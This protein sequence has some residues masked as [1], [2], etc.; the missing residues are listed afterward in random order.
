MAFT[1][2]AGD[3]SASTFH[4]AVKAVLPIAIAA[5][6]LMLGGSLMWL[7]VPLR[8]DAMGASDRQIGLL[9]TG[10]FIGFLGG[11]LFAS[12]LIRRLRHLKAFFF[13]A[14]IAALAAVGFTLANS[15]PLFFLLRVAYGFANAGYFIAMESW[16]NELAKNEVRSR[17]MTF[18]M[19]CYYLAGGAG[20]LLIN[21]WPP[22]DDTGLWVAAIV[23][24]AAVIP[25]LQLRQPERQARSSPSAGIQA[26]WRLAPLGVIG[27]IVAGV[28]SGG[29][30]GFLPVVAGDL[31]LDLAGISYVTTAVSTGPFLVMWLFS[32]FS[33]KRGRRQAIQA[34]NLLVAASAL[35]AFALSDGPV[36][37]FGFV[38][39]VFVMG[40]AMASI[41]PNA[42][43]AAFDRLP[44]EAY[45]GA[46]SLLL[47]SWA[48]GGVVG[49]FLSTPLIEW[50]GPKGLFLF[51]AACGLLFF[52]SL[53]LPLRPK[54]ALA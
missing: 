37:L 32:R 2:F 42:I 10:Y 24:L 22:G 30:H 3:M 50:L 31:G 9:A 35:G 26:L 40:G 13:C 29:V 12:P 53:L 36:S 33:D 1:I 34:I 46:S 11:G 19:S 44:Q 6:F 15:F 18:Y 5:S 47:L 25:L 14:V 7:S 38:A 16:L 49:P 43:A 41:Y 52:L 51:P 45:V 17:A 48:A 4:E 23:L 8:L 21:L 27:S 39:L 54:K 28:M 20:Q